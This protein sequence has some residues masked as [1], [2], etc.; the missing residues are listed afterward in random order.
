MRSVGFLADFPATQLGEKANLR[1]TLLPEE[2]NV[3]QLLTLLTKFFLKMISSIT[4]IRQSFI[5]EF[6]PKL[7]EVGVNALMKTLIQYT[8]R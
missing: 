6:Y 2:T 3:C 8:E 4:N 1:K 5:L 7:R